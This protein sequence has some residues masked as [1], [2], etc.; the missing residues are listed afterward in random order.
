MSCILVK[1]LPCMQ[2]CYKGSSNYKKN[3][4]IEKGKCE[5]L[6]GMYKFIFECFPKYEV[7]ECCDINN[8]R[9]FPEV[10]LEDFAKNK[11]IA[12]EMKCFPDKVYRDVKQT[13]K[14]NKKEAFFWNKVIDKCGFEARKEIISWLKSI[15]INKNEEIEE[16]LKIIFYPMNIKLVSKEKE[17][18]QYILMKDKYD[19]KQMKFIIEK[20]VLFCKELFKNLIYKNKISVIET[21]EN[22]EIKVCIY[23]GK[24]KTPYFEIHD[25]LIS[26]LGDIMNINKDGITEYLIKFMQECEKKFS[27]VQ[28]DRRILL[29]DNNF[30]SYKR[31]RIIRECLEKLSIPTCIDEIWICKKEYEDEYNEDGDPVY[32]YIANISYE[33]IYEK[34][35]C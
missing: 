7:V 22:E 34:E 3:K 26:T 10:V 35:V 17:S 25:N 6:N 29:L 2:E 18:I 23:L 16:L 11:R 12:I 14:R 27:N 33:K 19:N 5:F 15:N 9:A 30:I 13:E 8:E 4:C 24:N 32:T 31:D 1:I 28:V 21:Y 20:M